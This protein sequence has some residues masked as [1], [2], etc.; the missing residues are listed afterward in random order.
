MA[1]RSDKIVNILLALAWVLLIV[2]IGRI[3]FDKPT[4][5]AG[6]EHT[7]TAVDGEFSEPEPSPIPL[8]RIIYV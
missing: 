3:Y 6:A 1:S 8:V 4:Q 2:R 5:V 7:N